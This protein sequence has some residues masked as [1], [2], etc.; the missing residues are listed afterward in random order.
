[1]DIPIW[2]Q[3]SIWENKK[4]TYFLIVF[5][6]LLWFLLSFIVW[7]FFTTEYWFL[8]YDFF[9]FVW[10][11]YFWIFLI[12]LVWFFILINNPSSIIYSLTNTKELSRKQ[13][14]EIYNIVENLCISRW[15]P[16][17]KIGL[18][19]DDSMN[20]FATGWKINDS[21]IAFS[22]W[23]LRKLTKREIEAVAAHELSHI[24][25][26]DTKLMLIATTYIWVITLIW[27]F[28][29]DIWL[30]RWRHSSSKNNGKGWAWLLII[31][32]VFYLFWFVILPFIRLAISRKRE[33]LADAWSVELTHDSQSLISAL[34]KI[35]NDPT[36]EW[37]TNKSLSWIFISDPY[38][39][40]LK[41]T[42]NE[43]GL[44]PKKPLFWDFFSTHPSIE[45]RILHL[46][47]Y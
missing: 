42:E 39:K 45:N 23:L 3:T 12:F 9:V 1:M 10:I 46:K 40:W 29:I 47:N 30:R 33:Y 11:V 5:M 14:P 27:R 2:L 19:D 35:Q 16:M 4:K 8:T 7:V 41:I 34:R 17:V 18:I 44:K 43:T 15:I 26:E 32:L 36:I 6:F 13:C 38:A 31:W 21:Y 28:F 25:N 24:L 37:I 22:R 20:A